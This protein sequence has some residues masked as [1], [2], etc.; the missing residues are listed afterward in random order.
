[1]MR[2][3]CVAAYCLAAAWAAALATGAP[4]VAAE[5]NAA[6]LLERRQQ[7]ELAALKAAVQKLRHAQPRETQREPYDKLIARLASFAGANRK[8]AKS[9]DA[10]FV[11]A[12]LKG[13]IYELSR[14]EADRATAI[15]AFVSVADHYK[16]SNL[17]DDALLEAARLCSDKKRARALL[18]RVVGMGSEADEHDAAADLL[19]ELSAD[20]PLV[21]PSLPT[22]PL[23]TGGSPERAL[24]K[25][26]DG[27]PKDA[28]TSVDVLPDRPPTGTSPRKLLGIERVRTTAESRVRVRLSGDV[29]VTRG[30]VDSE[31]GHPR[32]IY[33]D[34]APARLGVHSLPAVEVDDGVIHRVRA[35]QY[36]NEVVRLVLELASDADPLLTIQKKPFE[37]VFTSPRPKAEQPPPS[38]AELIA[39]AIPDTPEHP[40]DKDG[41][42]T[43]AEK[44]PDKQ[45]PHEAQKG[46]EAA[47]AGAAAA[48]NKQAPLG[49]RVHRVVLDAGHGGV[50]T[51]AIGPTGVR[52][53]DVT[54]QLVKRVRDKIHLE[55]PTVE[56][57]LT[58]KDDTTTALQQRTNVANGA[59]ADLFISI[60][61][62]ASPSRRVRGVE[63][64]YLNLTHDRYAIR[65]ASREN[66][67]TGEASISDLDYIL[68][69]LA[70][71]SNTDDS[72]GLGRQVQGAVM[73]KLRA[74]WS[75]VPDLGLKHALFYVLMGNHMPSIL[76]ESSFVSNQTEEQR[77]ASDTYQDALADGVVQGLRRFVEERQA[78][79]AP[80]DAP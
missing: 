53:K 1:M 25:P 23:A 58:R 16:T 41:V 61:C 11:A 51:G 9:D 66:L 2:A 7:D 65:L 78:F 56:V 46:Q 54:L 20:A 22:L 73:K 55:M 24:E 77:L 8:G 75:D 34:L 37:I 30:V 57:I 33:F 29:G 62:N 18:V 79:Y 67:E 26:V 32:R 42:V 44:P 48:L 4:P 69:D 59:A 14:V 47:A 15:D 12:Q 31:P 17:A 27:A 76:V 74:R 40:V 63:T 60:H 39:G 10:L 3:P 50:D 72:I 68:A 43:G 28:M 70:M 5:P 38:R 6:T 45:T 49:L 71:K 36:D 52:E 13:E 21:R 19:S 80:S 64:Y 35:G